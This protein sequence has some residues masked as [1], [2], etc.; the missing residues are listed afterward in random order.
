MLLGDR[1]TF[2]ALA[3]ARFGA[4]AGVWVKRFDQPVDAAWFLPILRGLDN[5]DVLKL[6]ERGKEDVFVRLLDASVPS[7]ASVETDIYLLLHVLDLNA[8]PAAAVAEQVKRISPK[9]IRTSIQEAKLAT[10]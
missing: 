2:A 3:E 7:N 4:E 1:K 9:T 6:E 5:R 10:A 8:A